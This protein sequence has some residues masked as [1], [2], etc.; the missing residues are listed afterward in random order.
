[1][2]KRIREEYGTPKGQPNFKLYRAMLT[3]N[4]LSLGINPI[5]N[6]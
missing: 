1:M 3:I 5:D 6:D 4:L 2:L